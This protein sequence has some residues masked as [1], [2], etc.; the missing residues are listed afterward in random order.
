MAHRI[1]ALDN[2]RS[3]YGTQA[4]NNPWNRE[5]SLNKSKE[6]HRCPKGIAIDLPATPSWVCPLVQDTSSPYVASR[7]HRSA[8]ATHQSGTAIPAEHGRS[9]QPSRPSNRVQNTSAAKQ[10][11]TFTPTFTSSGPLRTRCKSSRRVRR[12]SLG[13]S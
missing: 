1:P 11:K 9:I 6:T 12:H 3:Q 13:K 5:H 2:T 8:Q 4:E 10:R 7:R